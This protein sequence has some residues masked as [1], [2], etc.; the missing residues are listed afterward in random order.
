MVFIK[1]LQETEPNATHLGGDSFNGLA[2]FCPLTSSFSTL[3]PPYCSLTK[4][5]YQFQDGNFVIF[6]W[7]CCFDEARVIINVF[8]FPLPI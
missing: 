1:Q 4:R 3:V 8:I 7:V 5:I 6:G 2:I